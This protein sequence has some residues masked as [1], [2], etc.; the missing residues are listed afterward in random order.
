MSLNYIIE[1]EWKHKG[2]DCCVVLVHGRHRCG[3]VR[4]PRGNPAFI[5]EN[6]DDIPVE[7]HGGL[8]F[9]SFGTEWDKNKK[10]FWV[11]FDCAHAGD[12]II[13]ESN[14]GYKQ[15]WKFWTLDMVVEETNLLAAQIKNLTWKEVMKGKIEYM[16]KWF[17]DRIKMEELNV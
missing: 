4:V 5:V 17:K 9:S 1:R 15:D 10:H 11:G 14:D 2:L 8:T 13:N 7:V 3:Y 6:Y 12:L 16:P